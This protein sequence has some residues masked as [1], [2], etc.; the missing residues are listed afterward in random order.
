MKKGGF[1][2]RRR[3]E[4]W[5]SSFELRGCWLLLGRGVLEKAVVCDVVVLVPE[6][7]METSE[8]SSSEVMV[9]DWGGTKGKTRRARAHF[10]PFASRRGP[11][12]LG[13]IK[14]F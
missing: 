2:V 6:K 1:V 5:T 8:H 13:T 11:A 14:Q 7:S 10:V 9:A 3:K 4:A 12:P